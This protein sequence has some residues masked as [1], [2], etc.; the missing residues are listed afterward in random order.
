MFE[1]KQ[2]P[3]SD[4]LADFRPTEDWVLLRKV[5][6]ADKQGLRLTASGLY[7]DA[8]AADQDADTFTGNVLK[9]GPGRWLPNGKHAPTEV[10]FGDR[11]V[12]PCHAGQTDVA[13]LFDLEKGIVLV[14]ER[15]LLG[16][17][18]T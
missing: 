4:R 2:R 18:V 3:S 8:D 14:R 16:I 13:K 11:V 9:V 5:K 10:K 12:Y 6:D 17:V 15:D 7:V 1:T